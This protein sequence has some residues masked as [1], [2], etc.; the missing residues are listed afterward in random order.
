[1]EVDLPTAAGQNP[2]WFDVASCASYHSDAIER[3]CTID[4]GGKTY[5]VDGQISILPPAPPYAGF[6]QF[7]PGYAPLPQDLDATSDSPAIRVLAAPALA[8]SPCCPDPGVTIRPPVQV[9]I[10]SERGLLVT[11]TDPIP[12][13]DEVRITLLFGALY[14]GRIS[15]CTLPATRWCDAAAANSISFGMGFDVGTGPR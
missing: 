12:Y 5:R 8:N 14:K 15:P 11:M 4:G 1:L 3:A 2:V 7:R 9:S 6:F 13:G 10:P